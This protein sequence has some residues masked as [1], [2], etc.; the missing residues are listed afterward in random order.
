MYVRHVY[1]NEEQEGNQGNK[2]TIQKK[3]RQQIARMM[4]YNK[5][6]SQGIVKSLAMPPRSSPVAN[7]YSINI[8]G[9]NTEYYIK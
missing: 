2:Q 1:T 3:S 7:L 5:E 8:W 4:L 6:N 9:K